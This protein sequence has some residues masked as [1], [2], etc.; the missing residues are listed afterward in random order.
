MC[1]CR[2]LVFREAVRQV[3]GQSG[4]LHIQSNACNAGTINLFEQSFF[5][6]KAGSDPDILREL[7][8][9]KNQDYILPHL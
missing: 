8:R 5:S 6:M 2:V 1:R 3:F 4:L 9:L 7:E